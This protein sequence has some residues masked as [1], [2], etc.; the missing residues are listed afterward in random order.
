M[1]SKIQAGELESDVLVRRED[2]ED[3]VPA[4]FGVV[5]RSKPKA[6]TSVI[7]A[8]VAA[9]TEQP[10]PSPPQREVA[11]AEPPPEAPAPEPPRQAAPI[12]VTAGKAPAQPGRVKVT[13]AAAAPAPGRKKWFYYHEGKEHGPCS[14]RDI[15]G[16]IEAKELPETVPI[17]RE[18]SDDYVAVAD[19]IRRSKSGRT[20]GR[21][22]AETG[23]DESTESVLSE[24][25]R[26][27]ATADPASK[28]PARPAPGPG[29]G[30]GLPKFFKPRSADAEPPSPEPGADDEART[31]RRSK[32]KRRAK[33][34]AVVVLSVVLCSFVG[35]WF[36]E[37]HL[38]NKLTEEELLDRE[39][40]LG[41]SRFLKS[42]ARAR[43][44]AK[45]KARQEAERKAAAEAEKRKRVTQLTEI[46]TS[47]TNSILMRFVPVAGTKVLF[48]VHET[49]VQDYMRFVQTTQREWTK[50]PFPQEPT[51]PA[52][53]VTWEDAVAFC[54][55]L[56]AKERASGFLGQQ[57]E[58]SLPTDNDWSAAAGLPA[59]PGNLPAE[60][61]LKL[62]NVYAWG[63]NWPPTLASANLG[64]SLEMDDFEFTS[65]VGSF[66]PNQFGLQDISGNVAEW[67]LDW[68]DNFRTA[69]VA[70]GGSFKDS[71]SSSLQLS[72]RGSKPPARRFADVGFRL[73][74]IVGDASPPPPPPAK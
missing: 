52:V 38:D 47:W 40:H 21:V 73:T 28:R 22:G 45:E 10:A 18:D 63:T 31:L 20:T 27:S 23:S 33:W 50:S 53:N 72:Y 67:C 41:G 37:N 64:Q 29:S 44:L 56:T 66:P 48:C 13:A 69:H 71:S 8:K 49:R 61:N 9:P 46:G 5:P 70:R 34:S 24:T 58:Y 68:M 62:R 43:V 32:L 36:W 2:D 6:T 11:P 15:I 51:H 30:T 3:F 4:Y 16:M 57:D 35:R 1:I 39:K 74:V 26:I 55:W 7:Q 19:V 60:R 54:R 14:D 65:P 25:N 17:R 12:R 42:K 59:E